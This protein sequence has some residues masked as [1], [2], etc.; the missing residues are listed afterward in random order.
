[1]IQDGVMERP[2]IIKEVSAL[3]QSFSLFTEEVAVKLPASQ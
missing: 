2:Y 3:L 1:M